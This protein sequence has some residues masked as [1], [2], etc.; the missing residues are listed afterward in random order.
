MELRGKVVKESFGQGTKSERLA[1]QLVTPT[2]KYVLRR[3]G[4]NAFK[5]PVL[6]ELVGKT[7]VASGV[8]HDY[9]FMMSEWK[10]VPSD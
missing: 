1:V 4:Q 8:I 5:D 2:G 6:E 9:V 10:E 7:I 3:S